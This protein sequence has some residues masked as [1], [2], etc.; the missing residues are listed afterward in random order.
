MCLNHATWV[1]ETLWEKPIE[2][3]GNCFFAANGAQMGPNGE[4]EHLW[5]RE[6]V[7]KEVADHSAFYARFLTRGTVAQWCRM[8][9]V[10]GVW[11][12]NL[13][14]YAAA[15]VLVRPLII[16]RVGTSQPP[17]CIVP[18]IFDDT[19]ELRPYYLL[20]DESTP[21]SEHYTALFPEPVAAAAG[22]QRGR[23]LIEALKPRQQAGAQRMPASR[24]ATKNV[25]RRIT[26]TT[27][28][29]TIYKATMRAPRK[30]IYKATM[31]AP[32]K[33]SLDALRRVA[34]AAGVKVQPYV[35]GQRRS[36]T[37]AQILHAMQNAPP[38]PSR[39]FVGK[40]ELRRE[41]RKRGLA[42][43]YYDENGQRRSWTRPEMLAK[44]GALVE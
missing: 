8:M 6:E 26:R 44:L 31:K 5:L 38:R 1:R 18:R 42:P 19:K 39:Q 15:N 16:W 14:A 3:D 23:S 29:K 21:G 10:E 28:A 32:R 43:Q 13:A 33:N 40:D 37:R 4:R 34:T 22:W 12:D 25:T 27:T 35:D 36:L 9:G 41:C 7:V 2:G 24:T 11:S 30:T 17:T 20:L